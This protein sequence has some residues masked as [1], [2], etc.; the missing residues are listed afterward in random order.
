MEAAKKVGVALAGSTVTVTIPHD[1]G[2]DLKK[3]VRIQEELVSRLGH[4]GC[5]SGFDILFRHEREFA[6]NPKT[7]ELQGRLGG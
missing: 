4:P 6:V 7:L 3:I 5:Y 2:F 1:V